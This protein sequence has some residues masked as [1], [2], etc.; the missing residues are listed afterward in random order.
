MYR[1][2]TVQL[3]YGKANW[4][5][6][7]LWTYLLSTSLEDLSYRLLLFIFINAAVCDS[8]HDRSCTQLFPGGGTLS[9][10]VICCLL[11]FMLATLPKSKAD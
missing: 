6:T 3:A 11:L 7:A 10:E 5:G 9:L 8:I 1:R 4:C 2:V